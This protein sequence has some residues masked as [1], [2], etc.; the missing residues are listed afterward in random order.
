[1]HAV[2]RRILRYKHLPSQYCPGC[3]G[4]TIMNI[5]AR[6]VDELGIVDRV[7]TV[8]GIGCSSQIA[9]YFNTDVMKTPHGRALPAAIAL[10]LTNPTRKV[11]VFMGD[12]DCVAIGGNHLIHTARKNVD[13]TAIM[14]NNQVYGL[15]GGQVAPTTPIHASTMTTPYGKL[16]P[17]VDACELVKTAGATF[18]SRWST[19]HPKQLLRA[20]KK[21]IMHPGFAFVEVISQCPVQAGRYILG[22][23]DPVEHMRWLRQTCLTRGQMEKL[24]PEERAKKVM[25]G[26]FLEEIRPE[27][28]DLTYALMKSF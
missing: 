25:V 11:L 20:I 22:S 13:V 7:C 24:S 1:M 3:G 28:S 21:A 18:I 15:T 2:A 17:A 9:T 23:G 5:A 16:E 10:K 27:Y 12:G 8:G 26:D 4:G 19:A 14:V 6:A